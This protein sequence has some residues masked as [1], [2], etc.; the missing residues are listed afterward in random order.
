MDINTLESSRKQPSQKRRSESNGSS[1]GIGMGGI[2][3]MQNQSQHFEQH[4]NN[5]KNVN[6][7][8]GDYL[9]YSEI[10]HSTGNENG[11]RN[12]S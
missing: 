7:R 1:I 4:H 11:L 5:S 2:G 8:S 9:N 6:D 3:S 12:V 10:Q